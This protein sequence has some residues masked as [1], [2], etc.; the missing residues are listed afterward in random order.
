M[1]EPTVISNFINNAF[2]ASDSKIE[3]L[4]PSNGKLLCL[5]PDSGKKEADLAVESA[6]QAFK[7]WSKESPQAR[8]DYLNKIANEIE[9][10]KDE[11]AR[12]ESNDQG[13]PL[14]ISASVEIP[15]AIQNFRFFAA[16]IL[17]HKNESTESYEAKILNYTTEGN[18][19]TLKLAGYLIFILYS[20]SFL[21]KFRLA[22]L[23]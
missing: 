5:V 11:F 19:K 16:A 6:L 1:D 20:N 3:S 21:M 13:K 15:R 14:N 8:A 10:R 7:T 22:L 9:N 2:V 12:A 23:P 4:N 17:N 18:L